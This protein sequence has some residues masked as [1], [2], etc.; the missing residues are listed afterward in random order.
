M[1]VHWN[2]LMRREGVAE[3]YG[4]GRELRFPNGYYPLPCDRLG[5]VWLMRLAPGK[6]QFGPWFVP[7]L[8]P[9]MDV[10]LIA[11]LNRRTQAPGV[12]E[13][14]VRANEMLYLGEISIDESQGNRASVSDRWEC[15][16]LYLQGTWTDW[17]QYHLRREPASFEAA[18]VM[19]WPRCRDTSWAV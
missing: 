8:D 2:F 5:S 1:D 7:G 13:F 16:E 14:T 4:I 12:A 6:Y 11:P 19:P 3:G 9:L 15:D 17:D 10:L 18:R